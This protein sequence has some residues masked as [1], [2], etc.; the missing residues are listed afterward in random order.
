MLRLFVIAL[1]C[2]IIDLIGQAL[3]EFTGIDIPFKT[4]SSEVG[5]HDLG[6]RI[7]SWTVRLLSLIT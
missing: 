6:M 4:Q 1:P 7:I 3:S 2:T 5:Y